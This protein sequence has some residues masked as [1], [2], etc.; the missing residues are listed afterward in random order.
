LPRVPALLLVTTETCSEP[1]QVGSSPPT[2]ALTEYV[3]VLTAGLPVVGW[4][5]VALA[6]FGVNG[7]L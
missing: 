5:S 6:T 7:R 3:L 4:V 2:R 1:G